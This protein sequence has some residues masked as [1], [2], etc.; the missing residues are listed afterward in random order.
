ML[1]CLA[2]LACEAPDPL[3]PPRYTLN[4]TPRAGALD[5]VADRKGDAHLRSGDAAP[6]YLDQVGGAVTAA[7][8]GTLRFVADLAAPLPSEP[9]L[10]KGDGAIG[11]SFCLDTDEGVA[12]VGF[13][14]FDS[15]SPCEF[16][17]R[18]AWDGKDLQALFIDR[19]PLTEGRY[20]Q[21][22]RVQPTWR[23]TRLELL[24]PLEEIGYPTRFDWSISTEEF[25]SLNRDAVH[26]VDE[27]PDGGVRSP[28]TWRSK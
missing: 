21:L 8:E 5:L 14:S 2:L 3:L 13:P 26:H 24:I 28:A 17:L 22:Q 18:V 6:G 4:P 27:L 9:K 16:V 20:S 10:P 7:D 1:C 15:A 11:W 25:E 19:R 23:R 12:T